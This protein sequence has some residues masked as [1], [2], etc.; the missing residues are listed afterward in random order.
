MAEITAPASVQL[1]PYQHNG[2]RSHTNIDSKL[3]TTFSHHDCTGVF[4]SDGITGKTE[5]DSTCTFPGTSRVRQSDKT[6]TSIFH[7][8]PRRRVALTGRMYG[9]NLLCEAKP[10]R[11]AWHRGASMYGSVEQPLKLSGSVRY[12]HYDDRRRSGKKM[13]FRSTA[14]MCMARPGCVSSSSVAS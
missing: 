14:S 4:Q 10:K 7:Q 6:S 11:N 12:E 5:V 8:G 13:C 1:I 3:P 2:K 9:C